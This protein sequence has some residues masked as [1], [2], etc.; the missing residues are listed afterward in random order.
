MLPTRYPFKCDIDKN[1]AKFRQIFYVRFFTLSMKVNK[2]SAL[3]FFLSTHPQHLCARWV[4]WYG[5]SDRRKQN[6]QSSSGHFLSCS[7]DFFSKIPLAAYLLIIK[8]LT[9]ERKSISR[10]ETFSLPFYF[11][12]DHVSLLCARKQLRQWNFLARA[13]L[14]EKLCSA[15]LSWR[16]ETENTELNYYFL[17][18]LYCFPP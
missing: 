16:Q 8:M 11:S 18:L 4:M 13:I 2:I 5:K 10:G 15:T 12:S 3:I 7:S 17:F 9:V 1:F 6:K 14:S